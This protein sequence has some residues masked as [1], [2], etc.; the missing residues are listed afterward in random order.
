MR[1]QGFI[2]RHNAVVEAFR[3]QDQYNKY[4]TVALC[5]ASLVTSIASEENLKDDPMTVFWCITPKSE[6]F[7]YYP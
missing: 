3:R 4:K 1:S 7:V 5:P 6:I 2:G